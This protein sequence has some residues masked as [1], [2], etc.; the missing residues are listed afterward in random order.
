MLC[1]DAWTWHRNKLEPRL[2]PDALHH[3]P[4][5]VVDAGLPLQPGKHLIQVAKGCSEPFSEPLQTDLPSVHQ[6]RTPFCG[7]CLAFCK[8]VLTFQDFI[9]CAGHGLGVWAFFFYFF[10]RFMHLR[11]CKKMRLALQR[12]LWHKF[13]RQRAHQHVESSA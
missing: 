2:L 13:W 4:V 1:Q 7:R 12:R 10:Q 5:H 3:I 11:V 9:K 8:S 6:G